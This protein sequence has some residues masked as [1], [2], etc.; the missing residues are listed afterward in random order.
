MHVIYYITCYP[1]LFPM[2]Y[3]ET[4]DWKIKKVALDFILETA[5]NNFPNEFAGLLR[6]KDNLIEEVIL[7]P[8]TR[9]NETSATLQMHMLPLDP[10][11]IGSVHS[12]PGPARPSR[13]DL[14]FFSRFGKIHLIA[15][16]PF[17]FLHLKAFQPNGEEV[18]LVIV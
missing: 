14:A 17:D 3:Q 11:V 6:G 5:R 7:L 4:D 18:R 15:G 9:W 13:A 12:H 10:S 8:G 2:N 1:K 16:Y